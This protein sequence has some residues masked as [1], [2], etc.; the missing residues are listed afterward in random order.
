MRSS[1][2]LSTGLLTIYYSYFLLIYYSIDFCDDLTIEDW[3][4]RLS[5]NFDTL[6]WMGF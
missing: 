4:G 6:Y 5:R 3:L 1:L 2:L